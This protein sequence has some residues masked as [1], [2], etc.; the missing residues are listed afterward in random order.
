MEASDVCEIR[1]ECGGRPRAWRDPAPRSG[2]G[3]RH[4]RC[5]YFSYVTRL[6]QVFTLLYLFGKATLT[7][8][9]GAHRYLVTGQPTK[10]LTEQVEL[11]IDKSIDQNKYEQN[12][13]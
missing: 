12:T 8:G 9:T 5:T 13:D 7:Q 2:K 11:L 1:T 4:A 6:H 10:N 3:S